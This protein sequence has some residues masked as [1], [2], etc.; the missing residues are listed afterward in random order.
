MKPVNKLIG[1]GLVASMGAM[2][3]QA[4]CGTSQPTTPAGHARRAV[5]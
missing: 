4:D 1:L 5:G 3:A 2:L